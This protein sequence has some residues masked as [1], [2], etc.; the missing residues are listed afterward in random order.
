MVQS[1]C[2]YVCSHLSVCL[3]VSVFA[4]DRQPTLY[5]CKHSW[6][7]VPLLRQFALV[8]HAEKLATLERREADLKAQ[9]NAL[10]NDAQDLKNREGSSSN[11]DAFLFV[12]I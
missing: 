10:A 6:H 9:H 2:L 3:S 1:I 12:P 5:I 11:L 8:Q 4:N 7:A